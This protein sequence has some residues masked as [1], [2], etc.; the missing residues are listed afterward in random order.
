MM[1][2]TQTVSSLGMVYYQISIELLE[3]GMWQAVGHCRAASYAWPVGYMAMMYH[4]KDEA[5]RAIE[6]T[7]IN[8]LTHMIE[9]SAS[10]MHELNDVLKV[11]RQQSH[12]VF[13]GQM[14]LFAE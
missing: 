12:K 1:R 2:H 3:D 5:K 14:S 6:E 10:E 4:S 7:W 9:R 13:F 11:G 8:S